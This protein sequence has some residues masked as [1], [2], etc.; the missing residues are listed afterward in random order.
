MNRNVIVTGG[1]GYIGSHICVALIQSGY[2]PVIIDDLSNAFPET[3]GMIEQIT[4]SKP[5]PFYQ[6]DVC[7]RDEVAK[8]FDAYQPVAVIHLAAK[9]AVEDS[10]KNPLSYYEENLD[11]LFSIL[12]VMKDKSV[13]KFVFSSSAT[14]YAPDAHGYYKED[15]PLAPINPYGHGKLFSEQI[16]RDVEFSGDLNAAILRYFNPVGAHESGLIGENPKGRPNNLMPILGQVV[17]GKLEKLVVYGQDY[18]TPDGTAVRDFI[19]VMDVAEAHVVALERLL[20]LDHGFLLNIGTGKGLSVVALIKSYE[21]ANSVQISFE[22]GPRRA[23]DAA[24]VCANV[25]LAEQFLG[26]SAKR[27]VSQMCRD[28]HRWISSRKS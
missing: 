10:V 22:Y 13:T 1:A 3:I 15:A 11:G 9:K 27:D 18:D 7:N 25:E 12:N 8:I 23:G 6:I 2:T 4:S 19:H 5:L 14:V 17:A 20:S 24:H 28:H 26:W 16:L 21:T